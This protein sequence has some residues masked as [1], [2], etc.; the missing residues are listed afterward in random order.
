MR[1]HNN[2][3][4]DSHTFENKSKRIVFQFNPLSRKK[5]YTPFGHSGIVNPEPRDK[6]TLDYT[7]LKFAIDEGHGF[8]QEEIAK[9]RFKGPGLCVPDY[10][11]NAK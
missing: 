3:V 9:V 10:S 11:N 8:M 2:G 7:K 1:F 5:L 4:A 6:I